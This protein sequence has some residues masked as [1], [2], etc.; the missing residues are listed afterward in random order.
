MGALP[1]SWSDRLSRSRRDWSS[2]SSDPSFLSPKLLADGFDLTQQGHAILHPALH[3]LIGRHLGLEVA[4]VARRTRRRQ[5]SIRPCGWRRSWSAAV[6]WLRSS[7]AVGRRK[8]HAVESR[9]AA[10]RPRPSCWRDDRGARSLPFAEGRIERREHVAGLHS[11]P[12][13]TLMV[14]IMPMSSG[15]TTMSGSMVISLPRATTTRSTCETAPRLCRETRSRDD[16]ERAARQPTAAALLDHQRHRAG[17]ATPR[18]VDPLRI[19]PLRAARGLASGWHSS[20][21]P[22]LLL[23]EL[24][25]GHAA[26]EQLSCLPWPTIWPLSSTM[27]WSQS[28]S[29]DSRCET[30]II[31]RPS[32][33]RT[34]LALTIASLSGIE[35]AGRLVEDA[36]CADRRISARAI[37]RRCF[38][39]PDRLARALFEHACRSR[40]GMRSMNSSAPARRAAPTTSSKRQRP[41]WPA[42]DVV[43][44][45]C[46]GTGSCPAARRRCWLRR[47]TRSISRMS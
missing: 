3:R 39:P 21:R 44:D 32:T 33:M 22:G 43:A 24:L 15:C 40:C 27:I 23:P 37:A 16:V 10:V 4:D 26:L 34:R 1:A 9:R 36:G 47:W 30:M 5:Q 12:T 42:R 17:T 38:W 13:P 7:V 20:E 25:V 28:R 46:R 6:G 18:L 19:G 35:R 11:R 45:R 29:D 41:A 14:R 8:R 31:V 2:A